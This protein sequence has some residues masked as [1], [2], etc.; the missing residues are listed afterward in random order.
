MRV[1]IEEQKKCHFYQ[2]TIMF[3]LR[4]TKSSSIFL[5]D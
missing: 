3:I 2:R 5:A 4:I 1:P